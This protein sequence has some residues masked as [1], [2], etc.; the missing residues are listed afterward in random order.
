[1]SAEVRHPDE[2][3]A[4]ARTP[5]GGIALER[6]RIGSS[7][8]ETRRPAAVDYAASERRRLQTLEQAQRRR[9]TGPA[10]RHATVRRLQ[11]ADEG[12]HQP[13]TALVAPRPRGV[14]PG[15]RNPRLLAAGAAGY[16]LHTHRRLL[17]RAVEPAFLQLADE[18]RS[19][20]RRVGKECRQRWPA[21]G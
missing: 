14:L 21:A 4:T 20:E 19:E 15:P 16:G 2:V 6:L 9:R 11:L 10:D 5:L 18:P 8:A 13:D 17:L 12:T 7:A 1:T 3:R